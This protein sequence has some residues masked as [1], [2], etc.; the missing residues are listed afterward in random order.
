M[1]GV[2]F[3]IHQRFQS[4]LYYRLLYRVRALISADI[5][6]TLHIMLASIF[7]MKNLVD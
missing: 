4:E 5:H 7:M 6:C 2:Q 1:K 3:C